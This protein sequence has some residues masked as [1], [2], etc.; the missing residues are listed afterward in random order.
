MKKN[1][2]AYLVKRI[3]LVEG[4]IRPCGHCYIE[5]LVA[6]FTTNL[7]PN[8]KYQI[9]TPKVLGFGKKHRRPVHICVYTVYI[10]IYITGV[11]CYRLT[12]SV[13]VAALHAQLSV[14]GSKAMPQCECKTRV[15]K[16]Y[17]THRIHVW[18]IYLH[19]WLLF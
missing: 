4:S 14:S 10:Y 12:I 9:S 1:H 7:E 18:Y 11:S 8:M 16:S 3:S 15:F 2:I 6:F 13:S 5:G 19:E 17:L